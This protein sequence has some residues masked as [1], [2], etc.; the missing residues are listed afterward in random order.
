MKL[1]LLLINL[2]NAGNAS[3]IIPKIKKFMI[4]LI[5]NKRICFLNNNEK[6][7]YD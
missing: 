6:D 2:N 7:N 5:R 4:I 3:Q 1:I